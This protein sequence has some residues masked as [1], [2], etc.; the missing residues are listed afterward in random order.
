MPTH[1]MAT[2][3]TAPSPTN[4]HAGS[5]GRSTKN[6][7]RA[8]SGVKD[9]AAAEYAPALMANALSGLPAGPHAVMRRAG[10]RAPVASEARESGAPVSNDCR[11]VALEA[12]TA[13]SKS[14]WF[15]SLPAL[16]L[17]GQV[18][19]ANGRKLSELQAYRV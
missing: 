12:A 10:E 3:Q 8:R 16:G 2:T 9:G 5:S 11:D 19:F 7:L 4:A 17:I 1:T 13:S 18:A 15:M 14:S 6:L